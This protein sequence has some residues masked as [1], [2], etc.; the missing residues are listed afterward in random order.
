MATIEEFAD[1]IIEP[2][3]L[4]IDVQ[5]YEL[6]VLK[7]A[8]EHITAFAGVVLEVSHETLYKGAP[9]PEQ[10]DEFLHLHGF[11][12]HAQVDA[13]YHPKSPRLLLQSD[14]LWVRA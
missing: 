9:T 4:K 3:L 12:Q 11:A 7:G 1:L 14:E 13:L 6:E 10:L 2:A 5:G 8:G